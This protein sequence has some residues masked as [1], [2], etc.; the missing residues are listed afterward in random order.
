MLTNIGWL[1][2]YLGIEIVITAGDAAAARVLSMDKWPGMALKV[3]FGL[4]L[5]EKYTNRAS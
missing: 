4:Y 5:V 1:R 3:V 2:D